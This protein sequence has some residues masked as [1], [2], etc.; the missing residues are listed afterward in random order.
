MSLQVSRDST[1]RRTFWAVAAFYVLVG[2]EFLY[3][4]SPF[5]IYF[6][7]VYG[8]GLNLANDTPALAWLSSAFLPH[9]VPETTSALLNLHNLVGGLLAGVGF[10]SFCIG[11]GQVYYHKLAQK[12]AVTGGV[13]NLV[14]HPQYASLALC[15]LGLLIL[16]PRYVVLLSFIA[17][18]FAYYFLA[19]AEER[20]C[21]CKF[22]QAY[23]EY[24]DRTNMFL[25]FRV[26]LVDKLPGL[27]KS[28][29]KRYLAI[30]ALY[31]LV[32]AAAIGVASGLRSWSLNSLYAQYSRDAAYISVAKIEED[33][34]QQ[35]VE[36]ALADPTV[37]V[38]LASGQDGVSGKFINY[39]L[40]VEWYVS[41]IPMNAVEGARG[42]H[43]YPTEYDRNL[44]KIVFTRA[45]LRTERDAEGKEIL[46][47]ARIR[48]P[49]IEVWV[50]LLGNEVTEVKGISGVKY[51]NVP[52]PLF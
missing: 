22:G 37:Q 51:E 49:V 23:V 44:Y 8:P 34:L 43:H 27:P 24:K 11:A 18:V 3:M 7:S 30:L 40:P 19:K 48:E 39:V 20:E 42:G 12:G 46:V 9:I 10:V 38:R 14:R 28:G 6:Y 41:E 47:N 33:T 13:Y 31:V 29:L 32:S 35:I 1:T 2:F 25:P 21:E 45:E 52:V 36:I 5:A 17:M 16:W 15:S 50:D 4:A 26:G